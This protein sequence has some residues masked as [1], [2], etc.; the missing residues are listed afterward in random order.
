MGYTLEKRNFGMD[1]FTAISDYLR[2]MLKRRGVHNQNGCILK[3]LCWQQKWNLFKS[4]FDLTVVH[5]IINVIVVPS[6]LGV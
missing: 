4:I 6:K 1:D 5:D 3:Y 2:F